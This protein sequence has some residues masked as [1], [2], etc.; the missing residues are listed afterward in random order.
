MVGSIDPEYAY[1]T[2]VKI[3]KEHTMAYKKSGV[4]SDK[5]RIFRALAMF[6]YMS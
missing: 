2:G 1:G 6:F 4:E 5:S 3:I